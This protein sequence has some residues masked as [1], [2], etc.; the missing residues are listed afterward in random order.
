MKKF[1]EMHFMVRYLSY[2]CI[3]FVIL[4]VFQNIFI[5]H[6]ENL[7]SEI[8]KSDVTIWL[9]WA[10]LITI[11]CCMDM[12]WHKEGEG[13]KEGMG[14]LG[15]QFV[16]IFLGAFVFIITLMLTSMLINFLLTII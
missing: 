2:F 13:N 5:D 6:D 7:K 1:E 10:L 12:A 3:S 14:F 9:S 8:L 11:F 15:G 4:F 16:R